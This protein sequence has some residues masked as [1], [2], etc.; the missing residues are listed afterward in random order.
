[1]SC[2]LVSSTKFQFL[3]LDME[4]SVISTHGHSN[5]RAVIVVEVKKTIAPWWTCPHESPVSYKLL[6]DWA[7]N[8]E[9]NS[10][11]NLHAHLLCRLFASSLPHIYLFN[12]SSSRLLCSRIPC[13]RRFDFR[14]LL[15]VTLSHCPVKYYNLS[16]LTAF[17]KTWERCVSAC[18]ALRGNSHK[19]QSASLLN[20][21]RSSVFAF[22]P[23]VH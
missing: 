2:L 23:T 20:K 10:V 16:P 14:S 12:P 3:P 1:M 5:T 9:W 6:N 22:H 17:L 11:W 13:A 18:L 19:F 4:V 15:L 7:V 8:C 21:F